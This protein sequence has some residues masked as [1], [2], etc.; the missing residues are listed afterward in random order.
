MRRLNIRAEGRSPFRMTRVSSTTTASLSASLPFLIDR[1]RL[2]ESIG[3]GVRQRLLVFRNKPPASEPGEG[4]D[5][6]KFQNA[7]V[8]RFD[9]AKVAAR[10][11]DR[12]PAP[13]E[14]SNPALSQDRADR[15]NIQ[16]PTPSD[17]AAGEADLLNNSNE[18]RSDRSGFNDDF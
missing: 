6:G 5:L 14:C 8:G 17:C 13:P 18:A 12:L 15:A 7:L 10:E 2:K 9:L 11:T 16:R 3:A 1:G 4:A